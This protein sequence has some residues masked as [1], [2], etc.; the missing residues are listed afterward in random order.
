[1]LSKRSHISKQ[2]VHI[3]PNF[4]HIYLCPWLGIGPPLTA[5]QLLY[6]NMTSSTKPEIHNVLAIRYVFPVL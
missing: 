6:E 5:V 2:Q 3:S 4:L 1:M